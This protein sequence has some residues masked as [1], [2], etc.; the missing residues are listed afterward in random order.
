MIVITKENLINL[1]HAATGNVK[2]FVM[3]EEKWVDE[4]ITEVSYDDLY[5]M[6]DQCF[7]TVDLQDEQW[8]DSDTVHLIIRKIKAK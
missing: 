2:D 6:I 3:R 8:S 7:V 4:I 1:L 5:K